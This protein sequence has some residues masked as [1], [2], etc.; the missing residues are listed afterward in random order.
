MNNI[1]IKKIKPEQ[2]DKNKLC[3]NLIHNRFD[4]LYSSYDLY[5]LNEYQIPVKLEKQVLTV[6]LYLNN[7][8]NNVLSEFFSFLFNQYTDAEVIYIKHS[9]TPLEFARPYPYWHIA[10]PKT[11]EEFNSTLHSKV[12][13][14]T[15][16]YPKKIKD[17]LGKFE[18]EKFLIKETTSNMLELFLYWKKETHGFVFNG[19]PLEYAQKAGITHTYTLKIQKKIEAIAFICDTGENVYFENFS[20]NNLYK[21]YSLGMVL[22]YAI[23]SDLIN[24]KKKVF[25]LSG[26]NLD[27]KRRYN[28]IETTTYSG[29]VYRYSDLLKRLFYLLTKYEKAYF[30]KFIIYKSIKYWG[31][32]HLPHHHFLQLKTFLNKKT[33]KV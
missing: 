16:W 8:K 5:Q 12:R 1:V 4:L 10:F 25:Y 15:K 13:Y 9:I 23:I 32:K 17:E 7:I 24:Q 31:K 6:G 11:I 19:S 22:Y 26:G 20:Y 14:N 28:G 21:K 33:K 18:I 29:F 30:L 3:L 27:Y 2:F